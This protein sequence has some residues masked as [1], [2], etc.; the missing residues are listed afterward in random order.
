[1]YNVYIYLDTY[2]YK[3]KISINYCDWLKIK[4]TKNQVGS[5]SL[6][7]LAFN[8]YQAEIYN[9]KIAI[10]FFFN[11]KASRS[12]KH[13]YE[14]HMKTVAF[15][16]RAYNNIGKHTTSITNIYASQVNNIRHII[17]TKL[18]DNLPQKLTSAETWTMNMKR[19]KPT[20]RHLGAN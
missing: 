14:A 18:K 6:P 13:S 12:R 19:H 9:I 1:M 7:V 3:E 11:H 4:P 17:R 15:R 5:L 16:K 20:N 8:Y 2:E 10:L